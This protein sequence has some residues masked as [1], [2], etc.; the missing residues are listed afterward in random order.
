MPTLSGKHEHL[1]SVVVNRQKDHH[2]LLDIDR[3]LPDCC[4]C[5]VFVL[6]LKPPSNCKQFCGKLNPK[7]HLLIEEYSAR[8]AVILC[9][10]E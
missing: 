2:E 4:C 10:T 1:C 9:V 7:L 8:A 5:Y 3:R 6:I